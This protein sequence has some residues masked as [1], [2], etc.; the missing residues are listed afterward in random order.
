MCYHELAICIS[1]HREL[2]GWYYL[3]LFHLSGISEFAGKK[4][5][6]KNFCWAGPVLG[7]ILLRS[8]YTSKISGISEFAGEKSVKK[9]FKAYYVRKFKE[10]KMLGE[11]LTMQS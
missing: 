11:L 1:S 4:T 3:S 7:K 8:L 6:K 9:N 10:R 5:A 2:H